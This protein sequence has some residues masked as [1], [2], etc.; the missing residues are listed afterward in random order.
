MKPIC[1]RGRQNLSEEEIIYNYRISRARRCVENAFGILQSKWACVSKTFHC[2]PDSAK[3]IVAA[4]CLLHNFLL[5]E[6]PNTY[7]PNE[8]K[9]KLD[10]NG[11]YEPALWR[12]YTDFD[13]DEDLVQNRDD[14]R[15]IE[16][17]RNIR[18]V[19]KDFFNSRVGS[20]PFQ[21]RN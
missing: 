15:P 11:F 3:K 7:I 6:S 2:S 18:N 9:D 19:L 5:N 13:W 10:E 4:C 20:L 12:G 21:N 17:A 14:D 1:P 8:Y 16:E